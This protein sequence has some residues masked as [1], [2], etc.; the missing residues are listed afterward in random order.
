MFKNPLSWQALY[1]HGEAGTSRPSRTR[2]CTRLVRGLTDHGFC[3]TS[4]PLKDALAA[5]CKHGSVQQWHRLLTAFVPHIEHHV[6]SH[7]ILF[8]SMTAAE[9]SPLS[10]MFSL[11]L[12]PSTVL[13]L[14]RLKSGTSSVYEQE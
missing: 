7:T 5:H 4:F 8:A 10:P 3:L 9:G 13:L 2:T 1:V 14:A 11:T 6:C 12:C